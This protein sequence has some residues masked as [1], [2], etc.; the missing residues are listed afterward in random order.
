MLLKPGLFDSGCLSN[1]GDT[2][3]QFH[4]WQLPGRVFLAERNGERH[5]LS[6]RA[7]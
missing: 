1:R 5:R 7:D 3:A 6:D 4:D 2:L